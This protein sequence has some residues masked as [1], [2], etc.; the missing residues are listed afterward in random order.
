VLAGK[1]YGIPVRG[2]HAHSWVMSFADEAAAFEGYASAMPNNVVFLVDTYDT[3]QG[4]RR[5]VEV[6]KRLRERG[7]EMAGIRLDSGDLAY[8]SIE[9]RKILDEGGFPKANI[10]A[11][12]DLDETLIENLK[13]QGAK[14]DVWGVG[15][16][17][18]TAY[19]EPA[20]GGVYKLGAMCDEQGVWQPKIK[21]SEQAVK[22]TIPGVLQVR[23]FETEAG[24]I[25]DMIY[26]ETLGFDTSS[27]IVD[28]K[29]ATRRKLMP[30]MARA[31]DLLVAVVRGGKAV[32][33]TESLG[34]I[35]SRVQ[36]QLSRLHST[37]RRLLNPHEYPVGLDVGLYELRDGMVRSARQDPAE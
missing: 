16:K 31:T 14:I 17:L 6:G 22:T 35:R 9:A 7:H 12:N 5:A 33:E 8:L 30:P 26:E 13:H 28:I 34:V 18:V 10:L 27:Q 20:L 11:T 23:R 19:D 36:S 24:F 37:T 3:L 25:G 2:T 21:L 29:D 32:A 15:T 1:L 4:V